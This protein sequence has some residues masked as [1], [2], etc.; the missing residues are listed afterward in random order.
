MIEF[1]SINIS[2]DDNKII[3]DYDI[4]FE[5][6]N[7]NFI[8]GKSGV[9]KTSLLLYVASQ[10]LEKRDIS[11]V[12][13]EDRLIPHISVYKN[14]ELVIKNRFKKDEIKKKID[15]ILE[16]FDLKEFENYYPSELSGGM[17]QRVSIARAILYDGEILIMDEPFKGLDK[18]TKDT[19]TDFVKKYID[20]TKKTTIIVTHDIEDYKR[21]LGKLIT[22]T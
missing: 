5:E 17:K 3:S 15:S 7:I 6:G 20:E 9:G 8:M 18:S 14:L 12:F 16:S 13:Q 22:I 21:L 11:I 2:Y 1:K 10:L 4:T 19:V